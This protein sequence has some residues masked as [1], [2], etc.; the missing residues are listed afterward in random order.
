[1]C[2]KTIP[3]LHAD[4]CLQQ[5]YNI[6]FKLSLY[7]RNFS[8]ILWPDSKVFQSNVQIKI[9]SQNN[10]DIKWLS[11][12]LIYKGKL[13]GTLGKEHKHISKLVGISRAH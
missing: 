3:K 12:N 2:Q 9:V 5:E 6:T 8:A 4:M 13:T 7:I 11:E 10:E 1:M